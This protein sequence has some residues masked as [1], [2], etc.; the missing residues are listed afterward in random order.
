MAA[1]E[2]ASDDVIQ[3]RLSSIDCPWIRGVHCAREC[4]TVSASEHAGLLRC[5]MMKYLPQI[6]EKRFVGAH[7]L[8]RRIG[9]FCDGLAVAGDQLHDDGETGYAGIVGQIGADAET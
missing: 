5:G 7:R 4:R 8:A 9:E 3:I 1:P 6:G 2:I